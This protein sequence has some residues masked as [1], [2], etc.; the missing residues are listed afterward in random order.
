M[1]AAARADT[2]LMDR[3]PAVRGRLTAD[4]PLERITWFRVGGPAEVM[5]RP[6]DADDLADFLAGCPADVPLTVLGVGSN[7]L[8][9]D[10]G[11][12]GVVIRLTRAFNAIET[13]GTAITAGAG[14]LDANVAKTAQLHSIGGLEFLA[15]V[16]GTVGGALRMNAGAYGTEI[17]DVLVWAEA[18]HRDGTQR[19]FT[20][21]ELGFAYRHC[22]LDAD[23]IFTRAHLRGRPDTSDAVAA[24]IAQIQQQRGD[25]QPIRTRT[26]GSTFK[27]PPG[28][29]A[30]QLVD[31]AGCRGLRVGGA[32]V[33][34]QHTNFLINTG[35]ASAHDLETLGE[36][37][38]RRVLETSGVALE[39]E[40]RRVGVAARQQG[41]EA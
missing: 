28:L 3:L 7:L 33:S 25:S 26:S 40:I 22:G 16:P 6:A 18:I 10:G 5:V 11:V 34:E 29:K 23:W 31:A 38:R 12:P 4:A 9:R 15:G 24:R 27:N 35:T 37:V 36:T 2:P 20:P 17:K 19:R 32:M 13:D 41:G 14:T 30:W 21:D 39:W 1:M 8:V